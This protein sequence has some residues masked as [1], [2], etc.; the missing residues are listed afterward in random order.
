MNQTMFTIQ[1]AFSLQYRS[2]SAA[3]YFLI[4]LLFLN[5][6]RT[7]DEFAWPAVV[8]FSNIV[9]LNPLA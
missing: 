1:C 4:A 3:N 6:I 9:A 8:V 2:Y 5:T 7:R